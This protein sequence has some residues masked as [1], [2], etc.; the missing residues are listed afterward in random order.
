M[1]IN[2]LFPIVTLKLKTKKKNQK[3]MLENPRIRQ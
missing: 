3:E 1:I 2:Q